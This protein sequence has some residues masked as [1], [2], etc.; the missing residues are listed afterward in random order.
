M[1]RQH[2]SSEVQQA[3]PHFRLPLGHWYRIVGDPNSFCNEERSCA[4]KI[5]SALAGTSSDRTAAGVSGKAQCVVAGATPGDAVGD[6]LLFAAWQVDATQTRD[7]AINRVALMVIFTSLVVFRGL[8]PY[9][10]R[11]TL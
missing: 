9:S 6:A 1:L 4:N 7:N 11:I 3:V 8:R 10:S 5:S 2:C